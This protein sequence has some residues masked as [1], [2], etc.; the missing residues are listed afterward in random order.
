MSASQIQPFNVLI[1]YDNALS[2][3]RGMQTYESL[4]QELGED[5]VFDVKLWRLDMLALADAAHLAVAKLEQADMVIVACEAGYD[6]LVL[7]DAW[8]TRWPQVNGQAKRALVALYTGPIETKGTNGYERWIATLSS[9]ASHAGMD[10]IAQS[11][12]TPDRAG[13]DDFFAPA[14]PV[15]AAQPERSSAR[16]DRAEDQAGFEM[17]ALAAFSFGTPRWGINE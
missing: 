10:F 1:L 8:A 3:V 2:G 6:S 4:S 5:Y 17:L 11:P 16:A 9:L 14:A 12:E 15:R 7:L 13:F